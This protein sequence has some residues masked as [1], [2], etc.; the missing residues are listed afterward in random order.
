MLSKLPANVP[1]NGH[2]HST[3]NEATYQPTILSAKHASINSTFLSTKPTTCYYSYFAAD[4]PSQFSTD[5]TTSYIADLPAV[6][7]TL[8]TAVHSTNRR[9]FSSTIPPTR[10]TTIDSANEQPFHATDSAAVT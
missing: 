9:T 8:F 4:P 2:P 10:G 3:S 7:T 1:T 6:S 5:S